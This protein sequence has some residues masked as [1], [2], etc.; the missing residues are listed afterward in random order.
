M[1]ALRKLDHFF[2]LI[3]DGAWHSIKE[4]SKHAKIPKQKL[5]ALSKLLSE[6][7]VLEYETQKNQVRIKQEC[8][9]IFK[10]VPDPLGDGKAAVGTLVL[11]A[12]KSVNIQGLQVTNLTGRELELSLRVNEKLEELA[13]SLIG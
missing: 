5:E 10:S 11:P 8:Q 4:L 1:V 3:E 2:K 7:K 13:V 9:R 12:E 6:T